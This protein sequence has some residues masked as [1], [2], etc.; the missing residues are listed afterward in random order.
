M[1]KYLENESEFDEL[2][3]GRVLVD[4]YADWCGPCKRL[5][6]I[7]EDIKDIDILKVNVDSF[8]DLSRSFGIMSIPTLI[9]FDNKK[10]I[11]KSIGFK[12][13]EEILDMIK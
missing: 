9:L 2:I 4:F 5:M 13:K 6:P 7:L 10:E 8:G 12:T 11:K 1:V 3:K